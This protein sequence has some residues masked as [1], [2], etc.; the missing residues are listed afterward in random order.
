[1]G[2]TGTAIATVPTGDMPLARDAI[3]DAKTANLLANSDHFT[4]ILMTNHHRYRDRLLRPIIPIIDMHIGATDR[5][6][7]DL[8]HDVVMPQLRQ[9][10]I[11]HPD[12]FFRI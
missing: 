6:L 11:G 4:H 5:C 7:T 10:D 3:A 12:T 8:D 9:W 1:M 2:A